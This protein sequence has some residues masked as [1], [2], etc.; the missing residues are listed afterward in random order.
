[1]RV[2]L[3]VALICLSVPALAAQPSNLDD[4]V[5][6]LEAQVGTLNSTRHNGAEGALAILFG[7]VCALWAQNTGRNP[8]LWF[9]LGAFFN[10]ITGFVLLWKNAADRR[11]AGNPGARNQAP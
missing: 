10:V 4:R 7:I 2:V 3:V 5:S 11:P 6:A 8:W 1:M 9:F